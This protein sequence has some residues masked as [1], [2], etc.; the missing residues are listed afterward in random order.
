METSSCHLDLWNAA[1]R[2]NVDITWDSTWSMPGGNKAGDADDRFQGKV[3]DCERL[4][5]SLEKPQNLVSGLEMMHLN[6][7]QREQA[8]IPKGD[9]NELL[10][11][12]RD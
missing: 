8:E 12:S 2:R 7:E 4:G 1:Q 9:K 11:E 6:Q 5:L 3:N 10:E